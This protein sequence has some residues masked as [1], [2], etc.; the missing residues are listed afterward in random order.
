MNAEQLS[1]VLYYCKLLG[2]IEFIPMHAR[3]GCD[4]VFRW[5]NFQVHWF[6]ITVLH[7]FC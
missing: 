5:K 1:A 2:F 4:L 3:E 6:K 7:K